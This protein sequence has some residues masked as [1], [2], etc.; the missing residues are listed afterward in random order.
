MTFAQKPT[1]RGGHLDDA[2]VVGL[3]NQFTNRTYDLN[4]A[5]TYASAG[6]AIAQ[7]FQV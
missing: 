5:Y 2:I 6:D 7:S 3:G 4:S 1:Y